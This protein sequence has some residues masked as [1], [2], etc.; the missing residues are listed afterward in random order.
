[1]HPSLS[2]PTHPARSSSGAGGESRRVAAAGGG[3]AHAGRQRQAIRRPQTGLGQ[4]VGHSY[5]PHSP[6]P[7]TV[8]QRVGARLAFQKLRPPLALLGIA[9]GVLLLFPDTCGRGGLL[10]RSAMS[11]C[12]SPRFSFCVVLCFGVLLCLWVYICSNLSSLLRDQL[13]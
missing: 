3:G 6:P 11:I 8:A 9:H 2:Q 5:R 7:P 13:V 12:Q 10:S 4:P 1:M